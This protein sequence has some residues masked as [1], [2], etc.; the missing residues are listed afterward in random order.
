MNKRYLWLIAAIVWC[1]AIFIAT[2]SP[3]STGSNTQ[4]ILVKFFH[5]TK[6]DAQ[7]WNLVFRKCVHLSAFGL[8]AIL[9]YNGLQKNRFWFAWLLTTLYAATD[10]LH[11]VF[12]PE[13][14]GALLDVGIDSIG[15][16]IALIGV[17]L[18][19]KKGRD[20][21]HENG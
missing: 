11:Q 3:S 13:R 8:L 5:F 7:M 1:I 15:A 14:T 21:R 20:R 12:I 17:I 18:L 10:E 4:S 16:L 19:R 6:E 2:A 9:F